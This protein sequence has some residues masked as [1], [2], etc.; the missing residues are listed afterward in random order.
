M[1]S[2]LID[3]RFVAAKLLFPK[4]TD[5]D[6]MA[7]VIGFDLSNMDVYQYIDNNWIY[8]GCIISK[9]AYGKL[10]VFKIEPGRRFTFIEETNDFGNAM[11]KCTQNISKV[12]FSQY[13]DMI[14]SKISPTT[15]PIPSENAQAKS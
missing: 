15:E 8:K 2:A 3:A 14:S 7:I 10:F 4:K 13:I 11:Y 1:S 5:E 12:E 6:L 9:V